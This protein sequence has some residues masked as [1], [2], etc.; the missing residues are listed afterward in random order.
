[1]AIFSEY[2]R[3]VEADGTSMT[4]HTALGLIN[5]ALDQALVEQEGDFDPYTRF[6][7]A[8]FEQHGAGEGPYGEADVLA[9]AKDVGVNGVVDAGIAQSRGGKVRLLGLDELDPAWDPSTDRR[10][11]VWEVAQH[12]ARTLAADG[13]I[14]ASALLARVGGLGD[15]ARELAY[16]LF[17]ICDRNGWAREALGYNALVTAWPELSRLAVSSGGVQTSLIE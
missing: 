13:E 2:A 10:L 5:Q 15:P 1:M 6:A 4:V 9:R 12:L 7:L 11:T 3:V 16:R 8:W 17:S 14:E